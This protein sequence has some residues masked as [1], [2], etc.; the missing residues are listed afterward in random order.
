MPTSPSLG[1][2]QNLMHHTGSQTEPASAGPSSRPLSHARCRTSGLTN[3]AVSVDPPA[4]RPPIGIVAGAICGV[5]SAIVYTMAN[6]ALR[7]C[8][9]VDPILVSA[10]K[11]AP[12]VVFLGPLLAWMFA[13]GQTIATSMQQV[14]RFIV[15]SFFGQLVGNGAFQIALGIIGLAA[16]VPITLGVMIV[17]SAVLGHVLLNEAVNRRKVVAILTLITAVFILSTPNASLPNPSAPV[18]LGALCAAA[19]GAAYAYFGVTMRQTLTGGVSGPATMFISGT[20]GT[21][22]LWS[23]TFVRLGI[24]PLAEVTAD[25][26]WV[27]VAAGVFNFT[28]FVALSLA[29]KALPVV[30]VNLINASQVA[31]AAVAGVVLFAEP[32]TGSLVIG[33]MLTCAGLMMLASRRPRRGRAS[34]PRPE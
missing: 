10:V 13:T 2:S 16:A 21:T 25:Q 29:L 8:V 34:P 7:Q 12:T 26:W 17:C 4:L 5:I 15:G 33:I 30:A 6:I 20:V 22:A 27:M 23:I 28:A 18:W 1:M 9:D 14:P 19:S 11:A 31:M 32:V 3:V 24:G